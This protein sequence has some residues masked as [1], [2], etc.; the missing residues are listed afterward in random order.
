M[1]TPGRYVTLSSKGQLVI[2][3][4]IREKLR[5]AAGDTLSVEL[6]GST[7]VLRPLSA[8]AALDELDGRFAGD[9]LLGD[10]ETEHRAE[11]AEADG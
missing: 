7:I 1:E 5:L 2:P 11:L 4:A 6:S 10:L 9:D 3:R 8:S